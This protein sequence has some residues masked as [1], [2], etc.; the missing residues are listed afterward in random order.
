MDSAQEFYQHVN[1]QNLKDKFTLLCEIRMTV[2]PHLKC[3]NMNLINIEYIIQN[4][5]EKHTLHD[6]S[7]NNQA[8]RQSCFAQT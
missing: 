7:N 1:E 6:N 2:V 3:G 5:N 4:G 8:Y